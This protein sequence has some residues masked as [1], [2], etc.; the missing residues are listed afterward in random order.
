MPICERD[1]GHAFEKQPTEFLASLQTKAEIEVDAA[2]T[3]A[4][5]FGRVDGIPH[6]FLANFGG[7][8]PGKNATPAAVAG[9][10]IRIPVAM[11]DSLSLLPFLGE[12]QIVRGNQRG[13]V[14]EFELPSL[15]RGAAVWV[16]PKK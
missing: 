1:F 10:I 5:N 15:L 4:A 3:V 2:P 13:N 14:M 6:I 12:T 7:L 16:N 9:I 11:G 8:V